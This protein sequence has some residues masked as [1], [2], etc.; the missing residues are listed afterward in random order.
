MINSIVLQLFMDVVRRAK[1]FVYGQAGFR[2]VLV[3]NLKGTLIAT[4]R[5]EPEQEAL[6]G[7]LHVSHREN[8]EI[9][10]TVKDS[11]FICKDS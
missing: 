7:G 6:Y 8:N 11:G 3:D 4:T 9:S 10:E 5:P 2:K 1:M